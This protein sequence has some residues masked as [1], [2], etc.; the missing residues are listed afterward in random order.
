MFM[1]LLTSTV[2]ASDHTKYISLN[3]Q[4]CMTQTTFTNLHPD[5][6]ISWECKW[7]F[8]GK[9]IAQIKSG[10]TIKFGLTTKVQKV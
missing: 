10:I 7:R 3:N 6:Y 4:P 9:N 2:N 8:D 1:G 5:E